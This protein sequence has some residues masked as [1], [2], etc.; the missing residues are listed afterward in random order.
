MLSWKLKEIL[1][2]K[3]LIQ[4]LAKSVLV[5]IAAYEWALS[6]ASSHLKKKKTNY[7]VIW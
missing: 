5:V 7:N 1:L 2:V 3:C 4:A 6:S